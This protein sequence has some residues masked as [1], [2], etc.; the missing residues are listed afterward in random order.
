MTCQCLVWII[1]S[2]MTNVSAGPVE[3]AVVFNVKVDDINGTATI[4][5]DDLVRA[6]VSTAAD[7]PGLGASLVVLNGESVLADILPPDVFQGAMASA[8]DTLSLVFTNNNV[9]QSCSL[10]KVEDGVPVVFKKSEKGCCIRGKTPTYL[11]RPDHHKRRYRGRT[12]S[13]FRQR[14]GRP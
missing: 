7:D 11:L 9:L 12:C 13:T 3:L 6:M 4:M 1:G 14:P 8:V 2:E 5:L 10:V